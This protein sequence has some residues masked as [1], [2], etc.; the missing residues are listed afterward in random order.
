MRHPL[1]LAKTLNPRGWSQRTII[2]LVMQSLDNAIALRAR[3][4][5]GGRCG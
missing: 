3:K 4:G 1:Q 2:V 5:R